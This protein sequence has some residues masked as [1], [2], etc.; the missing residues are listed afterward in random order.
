M[1]NKPESLHS[2]Y[3][4]YDEIIV[5][6]IG[7][8]SYSQVQTRIP[9]PDL[10][11]TVSTMGS[12]KEF[13]DRYNCKA[14]HNHLNPSEVEL[15]TGKHAA[16]ARFI[17][18]RQF[19]ELQV[20]LGVFLVEVDAFE[21]HVEVRRHLVGNLPVELAIGLLVDAQRA[22]HAAIAEAEV[23]EVGLR[24]PR[25]GRARR[26]PVLLEVDLPVERVL[27]HTRQRQTRLEV[28]A[29]LWKNFIVALER[30]IKQKRNL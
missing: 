28:V 29:E 17:P 21:E 13:T 26:E 8:S 4:R 18:E 16:R 10:T 30:E 6:T 3:F 27:R 1:A 14:I 22:R 11:S 24:T 9:W 12:I 23:A 2:P 7:C 20:G 5:V 19:G 15:H 25:V